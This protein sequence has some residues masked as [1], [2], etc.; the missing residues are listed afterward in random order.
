MC[1]LLQ[2]A[3]F[4]FD[5][6]GY[7]NCQNKVFKFLPRNIFMPYFVA[8]FM[9]P[10]VAFSNSS[11]TFSSFNSGAKRFFFTTATAETRISTQFIQMKHNDCELNTCYISPAFITMSHTFINS[12]FNLWS[13]NLHYTNE[14]FYYL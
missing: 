7:L 4:S 13:F 6:L 12:P 10:G 8:F 11:T 2:L 1:K 9:L 5:Q 14:S 3:L